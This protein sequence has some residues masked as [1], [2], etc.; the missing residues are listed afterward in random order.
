M[1]TWTLFIQFVVKLLSVFVS[2]FIHFVTII[3][4][5]LLFI[6]ILFFPD[7]RRRRLHRLSSVCVVCACNN[8]FSK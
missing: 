1:C 5:F 7:R 8:L 3:I 2:S 4:S 6:V